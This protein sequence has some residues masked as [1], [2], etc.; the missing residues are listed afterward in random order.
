M[1]SQIESFLAHWR[2]AGCPCHPHEIERR[3][4]ICRKCSGFNGCP[5]I[6]AEQWLPLLTSGGPEQAEE[7][8]RGW[9]V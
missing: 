3:L 2:A 8:C 5:L 4:A 1:L 9:A 6:D 7:L